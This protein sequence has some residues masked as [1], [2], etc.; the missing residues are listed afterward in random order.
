MLAHGDAFLFLLSAHNTHENS[1][2]KRRQKFNGGRR[3]TDNPLLI[4]TKEAIGISYFSYG[5]ILVVRPCCVARAGG[6]P[7][8][9]RLNLNS[10]LR[11]RRVR[12]YS[13]PPGCPD[14]AKIPSERMKQTEEA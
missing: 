9:F 3:G 8:H 4:Q 2:A 1:R 12:Y 7:L 11:R 13:H 5:L 14:N 10:A 6:N